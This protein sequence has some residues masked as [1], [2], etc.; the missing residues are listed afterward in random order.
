MKNEIEEMMLNSSSD[1]NAADRVDNDHSV[2]LFSFSI[3][4]ESLNQ[5]DVSNKSAKFS[6]VCVC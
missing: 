1:S 2:S 6:A 3:L 5:L 4:N